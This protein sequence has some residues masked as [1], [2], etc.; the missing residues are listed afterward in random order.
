VAQASLLVRETETETD[1][2]NRD[3]DRLEKHRQTTEAEK[4]QARHT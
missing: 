1:L 2:R 4:L 3:R